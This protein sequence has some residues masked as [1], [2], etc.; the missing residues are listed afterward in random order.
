MKRF[1]GIACILALA[2][3]GCGQAPVAKMDAP[4]EKKAVSAVVTATSSPSVAATPVVFTPETR[5]LVA[6]GEVPLL[7]QINQENAKVLAAARPSIVRVTVTRAIDPRVQA[8]NN[9]LPFHFRLGPN[10]PHTM[11]QNDTSFGSGVIISKDGYL[12]TNA[13]VIESEKDV[14]VQLQD[15]STY[16]AKV[17][18]SDTMFDIAILKIDATNLPALPWGDSD[19]V[20]VGEQVFA[21]GNPFNL[22]D[23]VSKGIV[24]AK[25][26]NLPD[27]RNYEDYIQTDAAI[28]PGNSGGA[29]INIHGE[30]IGVNAAIASISHYAMGVGF[31]IPSN[32]V[33]HA[34]E[35]LLKEG[36]LVRGYL[37]VR[38]PETIDDGILDKLGLKDDQGA[39]LADVQAGSPAEAAKLKA[40]DFVTDIDGHRIGSVADLRL[41]VAQLPIGKDVEIKYIRDGA[42]QS[43]QAKIAEIPSEIQKQYEPDNQGAAP[44]ALPDPS[45]P[46]PVTTTVLSGVQVADLDAKSRQKGK[47]DDSVQSGVMITGVGEGSVAERKGLQKGD[48]VESICVNR[49]STQEVTSA[50]QF[51]DLTKGLKPDQSVVLLVHHGKG[52]SF[53]FLAPE[54]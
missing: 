3:P 21:I 54:K 44:D 38:L 50:K 42:P 41:V 14:V 32:L 23:S 53:M 51:A 2:L 4:A 13:H 49:G 33:R 40:F 45:V 16:P 5:T 15:K 35:G 20:E 7:E 36:R 28:N 17:V 34:V 31:A 9:E 48:I 1:Y 29:L 8:L 18:A 39:L 37:G 25:G 19:K 10:G 6:P 46:R 11:Q 26:R 43:T 47:I 12:V 24:S 27:S 52:T 22:G 30:L